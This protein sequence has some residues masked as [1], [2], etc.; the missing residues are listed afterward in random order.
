[1]GGKGKLKR[2]EIHRKAT[3]K[4]DGEKEGKRGDGK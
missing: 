2:G 4:E 1:M 3:G